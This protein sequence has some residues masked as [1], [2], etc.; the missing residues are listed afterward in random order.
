M[1]INKNYFYITRSLHR[2]VSIRS[3]WHWA[4]KSVTGENLP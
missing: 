2:E 3:G 4:D 1:M